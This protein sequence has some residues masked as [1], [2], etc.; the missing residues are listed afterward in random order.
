MNNNMT[1]VIQYSSSS[2]QHDSRLREGQREGEGPDAD[3]EVEHEDEGGHISVLHGLAP[4]ASSH[5]GSNEMNFEGQVY[6]RGE[7]TAE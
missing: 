2:T 6:V 7:T 3:D 4:T 1:S 5:L